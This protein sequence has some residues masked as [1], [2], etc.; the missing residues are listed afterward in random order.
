MQQGRFLVTFKKTFTSLSCLQPV[1]MCMTLLLLAD[2]LIESVTTSKTEV[3]DGF[4][5]GDRK[6]N[7]SLDFKSS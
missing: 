2:K 7:E 1:Q 6:N 5:V 4:V 3:Q